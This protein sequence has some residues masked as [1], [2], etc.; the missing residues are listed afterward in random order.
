MRDR[1]LTR[2]YRQRLA[3]DAEMPPEFRSY[4]NEA[5]LVQHQARRGDKKTDWLQTLDKTLFE[6]HRKILDGAC[7]I[8]TRVQEGMPTF[9]LQ[10][11]NV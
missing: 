11:A 8:F 4:Y 10:I 1:D 5:T 6:T 2:K 7:H 9:C 3:K